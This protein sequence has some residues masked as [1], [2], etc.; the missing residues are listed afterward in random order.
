[1]VTRIRYAKQ[2]DGT[3]L[4]KEFFSTVKY[5]DVKVRLLLSKGQYKVLSLT[6]LSE[7]DAGVGKDSAELKKAAKAHLKALG[8]VFTNESRST[9]EEI[10]AKLKEVGINYEVQ[11]GI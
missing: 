11:R 1:M 8:V 9:K 5:G 3:L 10:N 7:V 2:S 6:D 4:S